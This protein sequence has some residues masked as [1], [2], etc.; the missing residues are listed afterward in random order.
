MGCRLESKE[1]RS[2][3]WQ[4]WLG[5]ISQDSMRE[6][7]KLDWQRKWQ[8]DTPEKGFKKKEESVGF[9]PGQPPPWLLTCPSPA[10]DFGSPRTS[11]LWNREERKLAGLTPYYYPI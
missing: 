4:E 3:S 2:Q 10:L 1:K 8:R 5:P 6:L 7:G 11:A 9:N